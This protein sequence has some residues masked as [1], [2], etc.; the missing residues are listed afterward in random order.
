MLSVEPDGIVPSGVS[1][2]PF[3]TVFPL[4]VT[5][6]GRGAGRG[7]DRED[8]EDEL[9][10]DEVDGAVDAG[11]TSDSAGLAAV[12]LLANWRSL[13]S[14]ESVASVS[15]DLSLEHADTAA[16]ATKA[17]HAIRVYFAI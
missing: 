9:L 3:T 14:V 8:E 1:R 13:L 17:M 6:D 15:R 2:G 11:G 16:D 10:R 5:L 7:L 12:S 4:A